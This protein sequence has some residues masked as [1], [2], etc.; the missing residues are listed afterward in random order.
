MNQNEATDYLLKHANHSLYEKQLIMTNNNPLSNVSNAEKC[1]LE[2]IYLEIEHY[3]YLFI[4][5]PLAVIGIILNLINLKVF[6]DKS[7]NTVTFKYIRLIT[8]T[9]LF[10]CIT[11]IPY[12]LTAY[13]QPFNK[14]DMFARHLYLAYVYIPGANL[15]INLSTL[16]NLLVTI[17]R[18]I[19]V[20]W[21]THRYTLF[22]PSRYYLSCVIVIGLAVLLNIVNFFLYKTELCENLMMPRS[23]TQSWWWRYYGK[24]YF[25]IL[26]FRF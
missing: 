5:C 22:K 10:I 11:I 21:P 9:D 2:S 8:L 17:E 26:F 13:T 18:L 14:Y 19:S 23:F 15:A 25:Y 20:G 1:K 12:C 4:M 3:C 7:F 16:L 24:K 6:R